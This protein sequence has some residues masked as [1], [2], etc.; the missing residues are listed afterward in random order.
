VRLGGGDVEDSCLGFGDKGLLEERERLPD[1][2]QGL[3]SLERCLILEYL[4]GDERVRV[5]ARATL[6]SLPDRVI[7]WRRKQ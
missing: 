5:G 7:A 4:G 1:L 6:C 2:R 3:L